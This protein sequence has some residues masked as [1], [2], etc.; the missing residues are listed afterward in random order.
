MKLKLQYFGYLMGRASS[1]KK[2]QIVG[3]IEGKSRSGQQRMRW[4]DGITHSVDMNLSNL[5]EM[6]KDGEAGHATVCGGTK[7]WTLSN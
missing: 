6:V 3:K 2:T 5:Q 1:L 4:L 7:S